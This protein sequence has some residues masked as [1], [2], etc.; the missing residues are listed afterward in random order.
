MLAAVAY[1][2]TFITGIIIYLVAKEDKYARW[3]AI[4]AIGFGIFALVVSIV[5]DFLPFM[6]FL[7]MLWSLAVIVGIIFLAVKAYQG[8][9]VRLPVIADFADKNA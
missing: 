4:Q 6:G 2:L 7:S 8:E 1:I 5:L 3:H 9:K